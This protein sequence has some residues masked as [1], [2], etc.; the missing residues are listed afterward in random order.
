MRIVCVSEGG[1]KVKGI[2]VCVSVYVRGVS[3][4]YFKFSPN[5]CIL[6]VTNTVLR[7]SIEL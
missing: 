5:I 6:A 4:L 2:R 3:R 1:V 7:T